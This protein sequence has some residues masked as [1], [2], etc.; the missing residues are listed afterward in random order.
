[1][2]VCFI[3]AEH[4]YDQGKYDE[5][6]SLFER[7]E[8]FIPGVQRYDSAKSLVIAVSLDLPLPALR[9]SIPRQWRGKRLNHT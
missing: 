5:V 4:L 8:W 3:A 1:M 2:K 7:L 6:A 9:N